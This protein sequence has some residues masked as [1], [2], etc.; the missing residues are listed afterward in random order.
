MNKET[1]LA[2]LHKLYRNDK[3]LNDLFHAI[4]WELEKVEAYAAEISDQN[5]I[6]TATWGLAIMERDLGIVAKGKL[7]DRRAEVEWSFQTRDKVA[8]ET[9]RNIAKRRSVGD[10]RAAFLQGII[11]LEFFGNRS[12]PKDLGTFFAEV[13]N[14][15]P[16]HLP[17][18]TNVSYPSSS[19]LFFGIAY[20][21]GKAAK[22]S[23]QEKVTSYEFLADENGNV[24]TDN[25]YSFILN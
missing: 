13:E 3:W 9:L 1:L 19:Q 2:A 21:I 20:R 17:F 23:C 24:L 14:T 25:E 8:L 11:L 22:I 15:K 4:G 18:K 6:D 5:F 10:V 7:D 16:A 12:L